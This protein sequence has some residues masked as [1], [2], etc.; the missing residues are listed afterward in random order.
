MR[1][2]IRH[3]RSIAMVACIV[4]AAVFDARAIAAQRVRADS[5]RSDS[6]QML[7]GMETISSIRPTAGPAIGSTIPARF[8]LVDT[9]TLRPAESRNIVSLLAQQ[10]GFASYDDL[11]SAYKLS[12]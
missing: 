6:A 5:A 2:R 7:P 3:A 4:A 11:G 1:I 10:A 9:K 12:M 8:T